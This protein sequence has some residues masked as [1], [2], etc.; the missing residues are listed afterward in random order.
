M[1]FCVFLVG[2]YY[3][4]KRVGGTLSPLSSN[5]KWAKTICKTWL[6]ASIDEN[7]H[8]VVRT[9]YKSMVTTSVGDESPES[10]YR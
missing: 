3:Y 8:I 10:E 1:T 6:F 7:V 2:I 5:V 9:I 4:G